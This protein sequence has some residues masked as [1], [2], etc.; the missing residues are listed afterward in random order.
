MVGCAV[1]ASSGW[2]E[3]HLFDLLVDAT[4]DVNL[5]LRHLRA[6]ALA[7]R[8]KFCEFALDE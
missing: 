2:C 7:Q 5:V 4:E 1:V 3:Q 6:L 8:S